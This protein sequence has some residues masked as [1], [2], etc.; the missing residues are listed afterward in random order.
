M[1]NGAGSILIISS[2]FP[3]N[4]GGIGNHSFNLARSL[5]NTGYRVTV[6]ADSIDVDASERS[7]FA[8]KQNFTVCFVVRRRLVVLSYL[9]RIVKAIELSRKK[10][11]VIC[12]GKFSLWLGII[13]RFISVKKHIAAVVHGSELDIKSAV[14]KQLTTYALTKFNNIISVSKYTQSF[15]PRN[16][17][18]SIGKQVIHN[19][20]NMEEFSETGNNVLNGQP[21]LI[22]LGSV[23]ERKGQVNVIK[24][25]P[26]I[27][28]KYPGAHYHI[29]GKPVIQKELQQVAEDLHVAHAVTF[30]GAVDRC[31]LIDKLSGA[32][33]KLM[34][35][36]HTKDGDFEGFGIAVLEANALGIPVIGSL[37]SGIEDAIV[38]EQTGMLVDAHNPEQ[39]TAA[40]GVILNSYDFFSANARKWAEAHDWKIIIKQYEQALHLS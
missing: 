24:A 28:E 9:Y 36:N 3:P 17:S 15:V 5:A 27:I 29:I 22:T 34:L 16:L 12:S 31:V 20:I 40:I 19:G 14:P 8:S 18:P 13:I 38:H 25:L 10:Q 2:E 35:S 11:V 33:I 21:S 26:N 7:A 30:Y 1:M 39:V 4:V 23:T 32:T 37:N 6:L